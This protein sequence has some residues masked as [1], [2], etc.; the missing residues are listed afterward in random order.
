[1]VVGAY[2]SSSIDQAVGAEE[3]QDL[4]ADDIKLLYA[5]IVFRY[6][7]LQRVQPLHSQLE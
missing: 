3:P 2:Y 5:T 1:M 4:Y 6:V 7:L